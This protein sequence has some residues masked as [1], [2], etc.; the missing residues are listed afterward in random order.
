M[1]NVVFGAN[2]IGDRIGISLKLSCV[3]E[4]VDLNKMIICMDKTL[5]HDED[6]VKLW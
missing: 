6:L 3:Q 1:Y 2:P 4:S 5:G